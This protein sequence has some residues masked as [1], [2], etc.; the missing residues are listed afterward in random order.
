MEGL[1]GKVALVTG[2]ATGIGRAT[3]V[4]LAAEGCAVAINYRKHPDEARD[5]QRECHA[6]ARERGHEPRTLLVRADMVRK[7][8]IVSMVRQVLRAWKRLDILVNNAGIQ[9]AEASH[10][11]AADDWDKVI[12]VDARGA[13]LCARE[14]IKHWLS[15]RRRG[16]VVNVSS[17]HQRIPKPQYVAYA[18]AKSAMGAMTRTLALEYA[19]RG[20]RVNAVAP[21]AIVTPINRAW[22]GTPAKRRK[23]E[24]HIPMGRAGEPE[25]MAAVVAFLASDE[26]SY[27]TGE[28]VYADGGLL[29]YP[30]FR[31]D[32][33]SA[34][35]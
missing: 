6:A 9:K 30:E 22:T 15:T 7:Q 21:G 20:I 27:I 4:R 25:E 12:A 34:G 5:A 10:K 13:F 1:S 2:G 26:A 16:V 17:V 18:M 29:L 3:C 23:V 35:K 8:D 32:W 28:T 11:V 31:E 24:A 33:S 19:G 14:A